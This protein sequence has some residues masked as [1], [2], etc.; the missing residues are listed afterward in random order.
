MNTEL[1]KYEQADNDGRDL[2][3]DY[4]AK[5]DW[6][7]VI[8][9]A[10]PTDTWDIAYYSG[11]TKIIGEIK[12]RNYDS[13]AFLDWDYEYKKHHNLLQVYDKVK[14]KESNKKKQV[15]IQYINF[16]KN[17]SIKIWTTTNLH[18]TQEPVVNQRNK[19]FVEDKGDI[20]KLMYKCNLQY[21]AHRDGNISKPKWID[22][23]T[24]NNDDLPF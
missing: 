11:G 23:R 14:E 3:K 5:Q 7:K 9:V 24:D 12:V 13:D 19:A 8:K 15:E 16:F 20:S 22:T 10:S 4:C 2:F 21:E 17:D 18:T 1:N 6:C